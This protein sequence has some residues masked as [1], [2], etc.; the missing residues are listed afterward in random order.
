MM[1][2]EDGPLMPESAKAA[3]GDF[4]GHARQPEEVDLMLSMVD[5]PQSIVLDDYRDRETTRRAG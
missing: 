2:F 4:N 5:Q 1:S 3:T